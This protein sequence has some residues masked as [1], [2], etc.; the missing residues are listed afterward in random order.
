M[1]D[2]IQILE[3]NVLIKP[4][5]PK[6]KTQGGLYLPETPKEKHVRAGQIVA[7]G[8]KTNLEAGYR[9]IYSSF[10]GVKFDIEETEHI[11]M[12]DSDILASVT[13]DLDI[14]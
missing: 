8:P 6:E 5:K 3:N 4:D 1:K 7:V 14:Q 13:E 12:E 10:S 2:K 9:V 11:M